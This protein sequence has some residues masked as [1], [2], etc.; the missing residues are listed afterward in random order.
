MTLM[1]WVL[2]H[3]IYLQMELYLKPRVGNL[4]IGYPA[5][6]ASISHR[7]SWYDLGPSQG[8]F[9]TQMR[10]YM[11]YAIDN[12]P[13]TNLVIQAFQFPRDER[14]QSTN[15]EVGSSI[16]NIP[17]RLLPDVSSDG[18]FQ[19]VEGLLPLLSQA[20]D[21]EYWGKRFLT[22]MASLDKINLKFYTYDGTPIPLERQL[23][24]K[25]D[26]EGMSPLLRS[27]REI[28]L[29]IRVECYQYVNAGLDI[30]EMID[31]ILGIDDNTGNDNDS[32]MVRASN[33]SDYS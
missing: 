2:F 18:G 5:Q 28:S 13:T 22:P 20:S 27:R 33:Y 6:K 10:S 4:P 19:Y 23:S 32:F 26:C 31:K 7:I 12:L 17:I 21:L 29:I 25:C 30:I 3:G 11:L 8:A 14:V 16:L 9:K 15:S 1:Q 24:Y